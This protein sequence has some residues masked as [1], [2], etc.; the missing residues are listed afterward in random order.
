MDKEEIPLPKDFG[1]PF[2]ITL[3]REC[4][5]YDEEKRPTFKVSIKLINY[6]LINYFNF[7]IPFL[8]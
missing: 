6:F 7:Q 3:L 1:P 5:N 8:K 4:C 2:I